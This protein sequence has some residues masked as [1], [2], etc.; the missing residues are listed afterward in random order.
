MRSLFPHN[1]SSSSPDLQVAIQAQKQI[2]KSFPHCLK[3]PCCRRVD[4]AVLNQVRKQESLQDNTYTH[5]NCVYGGSL[6]IESVFPRV[7]PCSSWSTAAAER[8]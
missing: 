5:K 6:W 2:K 7:D 1:L 8:L 4:V 3:C